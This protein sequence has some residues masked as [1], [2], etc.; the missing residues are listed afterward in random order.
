MNQ[1]PTNTT[2]ALPV[3]R[4]LPKAKPQVIRHGFPWVFANELVMDRRT[5]GVK[6]GGLVVVEDAERRPLGLGTFNSLSKI[7][8]RILSLI[9][10]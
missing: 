8:V 7:A 2:D 9:H 4:L 10:I 1:S 5:K 3:V 6:P